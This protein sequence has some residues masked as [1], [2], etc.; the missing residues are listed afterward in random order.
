MSDVAEETVNKLAA[1]IRPDRQR[2][3]AIALDFD[4]V[5]KLFTDFKHQIMFTCQFLNLWEFQ[6]VPF[7]AYREA[8]VY[9][10]FRSPDYAGK[11][12]FLC[13]NALAAHL[14]G[15]GYSCALPGLAAAVADLQRRNK[16]IS[17]PN[18]LPYAETAEDIRRAI[19]W[20]REVNLR[21]GR[22]TEI[23]LTPGI[24]ENI[25]KPF[26]ES[27]DY[28]V[29]STATEAALKASLEKDGIDFIRRYIGQE[30]ASKTEALTALC[31]S[32]YRA[33]FM[34]GD[35]LEDSRAAQAAAEQAPP[36]AQFF[37]VPVIPGDEERCFRTGRDIVRAAAA[38]RRDEALAQSC[39]LA[40]QFE[41][42]E[43]G[44]PSASPL[45]IRH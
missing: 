20:S 28:F 30:T 33:V 7:D 29:V 27:A 22:L 43:A 18:L 4:G 9:I 19:A 21:V 37:F 24:A 25:F 39:K 44:A 26:R 11:E 41:G 23:G 32:G 5:C 12:R 2:D 35:S 40:H 1:E 36:E 3:L 38:G 34:F 13:V 16:K 14:A 10:N 45:S 15:K 8:Y 17:E 31:R 42:H 6:R